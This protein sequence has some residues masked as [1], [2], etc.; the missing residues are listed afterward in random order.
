M[1]VFMYGVTAYFERRMT[2]WS[3]RGMEMSVGG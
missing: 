3:I 1:G 2:G